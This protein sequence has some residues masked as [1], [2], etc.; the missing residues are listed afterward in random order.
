M[1]S[2]TE[3]RLVTAETELAKERENNRLKIG[4]LESTI[5]RMNEEMKIKCAE[6]AQQQTQL[7]MHERQATAG[8]PALGTNS[9][10]SIIENWFFISENQLKSLRDDNSKIYEELNAKAQE[11]ATLSHQLNNLTDERNYLDN[12]C[13]RLNSILMSFHNESRSF[14]F[15]SRL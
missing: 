5:E 4:R 6:N 15:Y 11:V 7:E 12:E 1:S 14:P 10:F 13:Q 2:H 8:N 9:T 3:S